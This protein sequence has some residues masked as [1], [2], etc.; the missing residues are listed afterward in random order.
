[1]AI[2]YFWQ[3]EAGMLDAFPALPRDEQLRVRQ[4]DKSPGLDPTHAQILSYHCGLALDNT[5]A[6]CIRKHEL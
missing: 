4:T 1:M 3:D 5:N 2:E 6:Y